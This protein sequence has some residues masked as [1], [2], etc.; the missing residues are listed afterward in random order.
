MARKQ[1][2]MWLD[3]KRTDEAWLLEQIPVAKKRRLFS[4]FAR[5]GISLMVFFH[6]WGLKAQSVFDLITELRAGETGKLFEMF[7]HIAAK[8]KQP[9]T[10]PNN[11]RLDRMEGLLEIIAANQKAGITMAS[12][13]PL[14]GLQ[15][16]T[17]TT[18]K[19]I[20]SPNFALP[21]FDDDDDELPT[22]KLATSANRN[23]ASKN[24]LR[25][26]SGLH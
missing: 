17:P 22:L 25:G 3:N 13:P 18:G 5:E 15:P 10:P 16:M 24:F 1:V 19:Q 4:Q 26:I 6:D 8:L 9:D 23:E 11:D 12:Q 2:R 21:V 14:P 20:A 7:P